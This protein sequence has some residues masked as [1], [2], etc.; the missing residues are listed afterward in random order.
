[1]ECA[2]MF[3]RFGTVKKY[4]G[5]GKIKAR[6][7]GL[8]DEEDI[9]K[10][11]TIQYS[12]FGG[13]NSFSLPEEGDTVVIIG[14]YSDPHALFWMP[15]NEIGTLS[16]YDK[17]GP[18]AKSNKGCSVLCRKELQ[19]MRYAS[20]HID[21]GGCHM[22]DGD[23]KITVAND[24]GITL[25]ADQIIIGDDSSVVKIGK[26][27]AP[28]ARADIVDDELSGIK[29]MVIALTK[30]IIDGC[31]APPLAPLAAKLAPL[32]AQ[33]NTKV[34]SSQTSTGSGVFIG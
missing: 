21:D 25:E 16:K 30:N 3:I 22:D 2:S 31:T 20:Y 32:L 9:E 12:P 17:D 29:M 28:A 24:D 18:V 23:S 8:F 13:N 19:G 6:V 33:L 10:L 27:T 26:A 11:P 34:N 5:D 4:V 14:D 1:M 7:V 15:R